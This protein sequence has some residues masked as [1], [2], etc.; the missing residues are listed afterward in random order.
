MPQPKRYASNA[1][2]Q[3]AYRRR[4]EMAKQGSFDAD[5]LPPLPKVDGIPGTQRWRRAIQLALQLLTTVQEEMDDYYNDRSEEWFER[6]QAELFQERKDAVDE[7]VDA[8]TELANNY[9]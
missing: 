7:A 1:Q 6:E 5:Y 8:L 3:A 4:I 9:K 2:K